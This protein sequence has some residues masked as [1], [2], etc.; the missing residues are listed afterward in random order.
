MPAP[1]MGRRAQ[2]TSALI[3]EKAREVFLAKGYFGTSIDDIAEAAQVSRASFYTYYPSKR[4]LLVR[5][6]NETYRAM[7]A[8]LDEM[9]KIADEGHDDAIERIVSLYLELLEKHGAFLLVWGQAGFGDEELR[10]AGMRAKMATSRRLGEIFEKLGHVP[11][12]QDPVL[13]SL[14]FEVMI[15]RIWY[16]YRYADLP[17]TWDEVVATVTAIVSAT[18]GRSVEAS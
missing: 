3:A 4:D 15:D 1:T 16:Y 6:G 11:D 5:I 17:A 12:G 10:R 18:L 7:N 14:A 2:R 9:A 8:I 13:V